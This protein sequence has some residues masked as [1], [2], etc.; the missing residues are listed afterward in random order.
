MNIFPSGY[1][2]AS[3]SLRLSG[4]SIPREFEAEFQRVIWVFHHQRV[5]CKKRQGLVHLTPLPQDGLQASSAAVPGV[6]PDG[7][8]QDGL[9]LDFLGPHL[10]DDHAQRV[11][12]GKYCAHSMGGQLHT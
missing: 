6:L 4:T 3:K 12:V 9:E 8:G 11:A 10:P 2:K 1:V 7:Q 5:F